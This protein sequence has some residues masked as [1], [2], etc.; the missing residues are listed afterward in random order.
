MLAKATPH[1]SAGSAEP[2]NS[3]RSQFARQRGLSTLLRN[4]KQTPRM[5][6]AARMISSGR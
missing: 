4:S 2:A 5:I 1:S 3:A 6:R